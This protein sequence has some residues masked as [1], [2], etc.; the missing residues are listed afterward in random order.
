MKYIIAIGIFQAL[1]AV[2]L[3]LR[4]RYRTHADDLLI[5]LVIC[6]GL[7]LSIKFYIFNFIED[8]QVLNMLNTFIGF[9]YIPL[10][11]LYLRKTLNPEF[12]PSSRWYLFIPLILGAIAYFSTICVLAAGSP[13]GHQFLYW[14]N[15]VTL[16]VLLSS[17]IIFSCFIIY[18]AVKKLSPNC[19]ERNLIIQVA[20]LFL[21][22]GCIGSFLT[23]FLPNAFSLSY[24]SRSVVYALLICI[25][26]RIIT[27]KYTVSIEP[28]EDPIQEEIVFQEVNFA[29]AEITAP[30]E[31]QTDA[32]SLFKT[33]PLSNTIVISK[34]ERPAAQKRKEV[35]REKEMFKILLK[36]EA[37][38]E[39]E[40]HF[41]DSELTIDKLSQLTNQKKYHVSETLNHFVNK[42]FYT[43]VNEYRIQYVKDKLNQL[44]KHNKNVNILE[45]A[46]EAGFNSKSSFNRYFKEITT[47]TPTEY[48]SSLT[49]EMEKA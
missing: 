41:T 34:K 21:L 35:L 43:F 23:I 9:S 12:I 44:S 38:M 39:S 13:K 36:L 6:I 17:D 27:H 7:H 48:L 33:P 11:Y 16:Y 37:A 32:L 20:S 24:I 25:V 5:S 26:I 19:M 10:L 42:P 49:K 1:L 8:Q 46:Y 4:S 45:V 30:S 47:N 40:K 14:Y 29:V 18:T 28:S 15:T 2:V 31:V 3:L 22:I